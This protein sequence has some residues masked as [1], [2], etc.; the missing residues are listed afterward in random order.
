MLRAVGFGDGDFGKAIIG[1]GDV[2]V[3]SSAS[4]D[5]VTAL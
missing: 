3:I 4:V 2:I 5:A 1:A